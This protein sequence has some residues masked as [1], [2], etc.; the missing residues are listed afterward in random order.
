[1][2]D[3]IKSKVRAIYY[4][5]Q[6]YLSQT[7]KPQQPSDIFASDD[8]WHQ[9]NKAVEELSKITGDDYDRFMIRPKATDN[10]TFVHLITYRQ[11]LGGIIN[12]IHGIYFSDEN[13]PFS[14]S[15]QTVIS[16]S[17]NQSQSIQMVLDFQSK[18]DEEII[19]S[20]ESPKKVGFLN[21]VKS[22]LSHVKDVN[23]MLKLLLNTAK[24]L[25]VSMSELLSIFG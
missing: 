22:K 13:M 7:P 1:M 10:Y 25:G 17:Q 5:L 8:P 16:Q 15:P 24:E 4:E 3:K 20:K 19:K 2:D 21:K 6:G 23:D 18:I 11:T 14:G 9:Y 12:R